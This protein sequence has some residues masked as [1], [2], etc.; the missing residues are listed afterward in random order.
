[1]SALVIVVLNPVVWNHLAPLAFNSAGPRGTPFPK[2]YPPPTPR[3]HIPEHTALSWGVLNRREGSE[4]ENCSRESTE[5][6]AKP[7]DE[8]TPFS[9]WSAGLSMPECP[10]RV[11][12][13][14]NLFSSQLPLNESLLTVSLG[15]RLWP[16]CN[17]RWLCLLQNTSGCSWT[18]Q[19]LKSLTWGA[20]NVLDVRVWIYIVYL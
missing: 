13:L 18:S 9:L 3:T 14:H 2:P 10:L 7:R 11:S 20:G 4:L 17:Y 8:S 12:L 15:G 16:L 6:A 1:M 5:I 19:F